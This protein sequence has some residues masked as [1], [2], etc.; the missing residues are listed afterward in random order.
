LANPST[1]KRD[2]LRTGVTMQVTTYSE[3][4]HK[5]LETY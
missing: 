4:A 5:Y 1:Q 2:D 3:N